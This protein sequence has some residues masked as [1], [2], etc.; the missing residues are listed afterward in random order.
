M[1]VTMVNRTSP[2]L[3]LN[4]NNLP[5]PFPLFL[6]SFD[7]T[8]DVFMLTIIHDLNCKCHPIDGILICP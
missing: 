2:D 5:L 4:P 7:L 1:L 3:N 8:V 6:P